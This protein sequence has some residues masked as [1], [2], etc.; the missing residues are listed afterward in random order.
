[1]LECSAKHKIKRKCWFSWRSV[2]F[3]VSACGRW[4]IKNEW[5]KKRNTQQQIKKHCEHRRII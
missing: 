2:F 5:T 1:M 4:E 3:A